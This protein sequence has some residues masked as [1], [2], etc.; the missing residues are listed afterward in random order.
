MNKPALILL[1]LAPAV[2]L[3]VDTHVWEQSDQAEFTRGTPRKLSIRSDG[4][5]TL[6]PEFKELDSTNVPYLWAIA[7]DSKG[8]LYYAGGAPTGATTKIYA[9]SKNAKPKVFAELPGLEVHALAID[10]QDRLYAAVLPDAKIY[11]IDAS[12]KLQLFFDAKSK[13]IWSLAF[14]RHGSLF[15]ATGD[16]GI[17][18]K[19]AADGTGVWVTNQTD[20]TVSHKWQRSPGDDWTAWTRIAGSLRP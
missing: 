20:A 7:E 15:V 1:A 18:Y 13:Y 2:C 12:G 14:D 3:A 10:A 5:I 19:V 17:I 11:R 4:H 6:A 8:T 9:L 16:A